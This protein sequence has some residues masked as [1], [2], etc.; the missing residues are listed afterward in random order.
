MEVP[1]FFKA[2]FRLIKLALLTV[3]LQIKSLVYEFTHWNQ[4]EIVG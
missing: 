1:L 4:D 3:S 2:Y